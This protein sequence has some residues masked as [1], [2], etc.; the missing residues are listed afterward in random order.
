MSGT[1]LTIPR[2]EAACKNFDSNTKKCT[3]TGYLT[4]LGF[5][6]DTTGSTCDC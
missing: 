4:D 5:Y 6:C 2:E 3:A 1:Q